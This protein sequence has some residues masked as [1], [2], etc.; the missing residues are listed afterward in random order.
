MR[1]RRARLRAE[2]LYEL[3]Q[4]ELGTANAML[5]AHASTLSEQVIAQRTE[6]LEAR[7]HAQTL[8][9]LNSRVSKDL[10]AAQGEIELATMRLG[11][12]VDT[13]PDGFAVFDKDQALL[14]A[15]HAYLSMFRAFPEVRVGI[16]FQ[17]ILE[18]CAFE[19][20]VDLAEESPSD[21]VE[22]M[23]LRWQSPD[24]PQCD[25]HFSNGVSVR[26][27]DRRGRNGD[28]VSLVRNVTETMRYQAELIAAQEKAEAAAQ[29]KSAFLANMSHEIRTPMNGVVGMAELLAETDLTD[30]QRT[31][32]ETIHASGKGLMG[33]IDDILDFAKMDSDKVELHPEPFDLERTIHDVM[34]FL[35]SEA[36]KRDI[37]LILDYDMFLPVRLVADPAR[38]RQ[39]LTNLVGNALKF[40]ASGYVL[41]RAVGVGASARGQVVNITVED[42]GIGISKE[43][44]EHIF[45][46]FSQVE[47]T[48]NRR[49][50]GAGLGLAI[51]QR[52]VG[53]MGGK[54]W[55]DS[56]VG[57]GSCF[58][59]SIEMPVPDGALPVVVPAIDER[60]RR[61]LLVSDH[62]ISRGIVSRRLQSAQITVSTATQKLVALREI[63]R[64]MPDLVIV[65]Q[66]LKIERA[67]DLLRAVKKAYPELPMILLASDMRA[68]HAGLDMSNPPTILPKPI[69]WRELVSTLNAFVGD[70]TQTSGPERAPT[71]PP[72]AAEPSRKLRVLYAEDNKTN[73]LV[74]EKMVQS[75]D[76]DLAFAENGNFAIARFR[77]FRPDIIFMDISMPEMDG[78]EATRRIR[79]MDN[80]CDL[81]IIALTAHALEEDAERIMAAGMTDML[82]KPLSKASLMKALETYCPAELSLCPTPERRDD[83]D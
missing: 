64:N 68:A 9:G 16:R 40:T 12:A 70:N 65:D 1:E 11:E 14:L 69:L 82:T 29:A 24:I 5:K 52:I 27:M 62:L 45:S 51:T 18:I 13:I 26:L 46:E 15:N 20:L 4:H 50:D 75:T 81:P 72:R 39:V 34:T 56:E 44:Q 83:Q 3:V 57:V 74:F 66:D 17:R 31:Y 71:V 33:I 58:G 59:F 43:N 61:V 47:D 7:T 28:I 76:I 10:D 60:L 21:W 30:E 49:F 25:L 53:L 37:E 8:E 2:R 19:G 22:K 55:L 77:D 6:I 80:G 54:M 23:C 78:R 63:A 41:V 38:L 73:R 36:Q 42:T 79:S 32:T 35:S 48:A 67:G